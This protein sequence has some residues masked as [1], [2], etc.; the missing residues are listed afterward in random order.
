MRSPPV[1]AVNVIER[2]DVPLFEDVAKYKGMED[3]TDRL[4]KAFDER[5]AADS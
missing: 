4:Q 5:R 1:A 3:E 2:E